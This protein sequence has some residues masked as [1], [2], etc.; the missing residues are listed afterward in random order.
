MESPGSVV[1]LHIFLPAVIQSKLA[2]T[3]QRVKKRILSGVSARTPPPPPSSNRRPSFA[4]DDASSSG[5]VL[6]KLLSLGLPPRDAARKMF[7]GLIASKF[8]IIAGNDDEE[9]EYL[10]Q[11]FDRRKRE[12]LDEKNKAPVSVVPPPIVGRARKLAGLL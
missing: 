12:I 3:S 1:S 6:E 11:C 9:T 8:Y 10:A 4:G 7:D 5:L 2:M